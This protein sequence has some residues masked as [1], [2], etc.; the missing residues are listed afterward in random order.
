MCQKQNRLFG[1]IHG[2][3]GEAR[4]VIQNQRDAILSWNIFRRYDDKFVPVDARIKRNLS[5]LSA[6]YVA[7]HGCAV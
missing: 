4:L 3:G 1:V 6:R 5:D 2:F 7:A